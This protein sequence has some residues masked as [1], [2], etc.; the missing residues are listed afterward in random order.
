[1]WSI[2][3]V[4]SLARFIPWLASIAITAIYLFEINLGWAEL[5]WRSTEL[6]L[7]TFLAHLYDWILFAFFLFLSLLGIR[8]LIQSK[9]ALLR[10]Y[11]VIG[12]IRF[13]F[14]NIRPEIRQY[15]I[16]SDQDDVP[17]SRN[18]RVLV[19]QRSKNLADTQ[20]FGS[21]ENE[22]REG[23][24]WINH[25]MAPVHHPSNDSLRITVGGSACS[26]PYSLSIFNI[27]AMSFG[28][29]SANAIMALNKGA[30]L[31]GFAH[32]TGEGSVSPYHERYGGDLIWEI[33]TGYFGCRTDD[34]KFDP[35]KFA[36][37]AQ[38]SQIKMIEIKLSQ[39]AKPGHGGLLPGNKVTPEIA[40]T[41]GIP[42]G[43]DCDS[44]AA[45]SA[46]N[47]PVGLMQFIAELRKL[48]GGK[49]VGFKLCVGNIQE[50]FSVIKAMLSTG[51]RPDF[52]VVDGSEGGTGAAPVEFTDHIGTPL[53]EALQLVNASLVGAGLRDQI[54]IGASGKIISAFD[55][56][57]VC[58]L[59]AD[60][61]NSARGFMFALGCIQSR[62]CNTD[63]CPTGVATQDPYRQHALDPMDKSVRVANFHRNT[64]S[65]VGAVLGAAGLSH[66]REVTSDH[67][68]QRGPMETV[69]TLS[70]RMLKLPEGALL[71]DSGVALLEQYAPGLG[72]R[73]LNA[74]AASW[75]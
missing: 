47:S 37:T 66:T 14:E 34:G 15:L 48:S 31:G 11:P 23:Y 46:F 61:A 55:I 75:H 10:N 28:A 4:R 59:G 36:A 49:P 64:V 40:L 58:A 41:R 60:W 1:M 71:D 7:K 24:Q 69:E 42:V 26:Q 13:L 52:I 9:H 53:R 51:I 35:V 19:Y 27:S 22:Y 2:Q 63:R 3:S 62:S 68:L 16:E 33:G 39:G 32:D 18:S 56:L 21:I 67:I 25:S 30:K 72:A 20:A 65:A 8:D 29:L 74:T 43:K 57:R 70:L 45:H 5:D 6:L 50:W 38:R 73:W 17:F 54:R 44:P 12:H